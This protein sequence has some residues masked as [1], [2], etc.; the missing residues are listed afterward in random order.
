MVATAGGAVMKHWVATQHL[1]RVRR[2]SRAVMGRTR[3]TP[4]DVSVQQP[5]PVRLRLL[6]L[7]ADGAVWRGDFI[8][9]R[10]QNKR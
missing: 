3:Q 1:V 6:L 5:W 8:S 9:N 4:E 7:G 2:K 10:D